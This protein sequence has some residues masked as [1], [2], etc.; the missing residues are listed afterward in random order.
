MKIATLEKIHEPLKKEAE[1]RSNLQGAASTA[2]APLLPALTAIA[3]KVE[4]VISNDLLRNS[5]GA[6]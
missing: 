2:A 1:I 5:S 4:E 6:V 3:D